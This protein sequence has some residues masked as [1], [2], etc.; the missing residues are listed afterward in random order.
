MKTRDDK[1]K[2]KKKHNTRE[3]DFH[4]LRKKSKECLSIR[5]DWLEAAHMDDKT[6]SD[7]EKPVSFAIKW[8]HG[9]AHSSFVAHLTAAIYTTFT[10]FSLPTNGS[11]LTVL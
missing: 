9:E 2:E 3:R 4:Y 11:F 6:A 10:R 1:E 7:A 5:Q 8:P